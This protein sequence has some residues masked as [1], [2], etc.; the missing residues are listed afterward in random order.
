MSETPSLKGFVYSDSLESAFVDQ[1]PWIQNTSIR[2]NIIGTAAVVCDESWYRDVILACALDH[3]I[4]ALPES[5]GTQPFY[6]IYQSSSIVL[7]TIVG[8][9]GIS[10]SN[11]QKQRV[12]LARALYSKK[13]LMIIDD[14]FS[15]LDK[16]T[17]ERV[18][19]NFFG[20][21]GLLRLS[22]ITAILVTHAVSRLSYA[23]HIIALNSAGQ[24]SEQGTLA[25]LQNSGG[26]V[27]GLA[28]KHRYESIPLSDQSVEELSI[29]AP[30][31]SRQEGVKLRAKFETEEEDLNRRIGEFST[32]KYFFSSIGWSTCIISFSLLILAGVS[33]KLNELLLSYWTNALSAH[34]S[35]VNN[36]YLGLF[37]MLTSIATIAWMI[38][39]YHFFI[40]LVPKSAVNLHA[41]LLHTVMNAPLYFFTSTDTGSLTN[42]SVSLIYRF[43][44]DAN[45][46]TWEQ[47]QSRYVTHRCRSSICVD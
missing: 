17:E 24:I 22:G 25:Q 35:H 5:D 30:S 46:T 26:F 3:D 11:G 13:K 19:V 8:S 38:A 37:G 33:L 9:G 47:I 44:Q 18:F 28:T 1:T 31:T 16:K 41:R 4:A 36:L 15:G 20:R 21:N 40:Y 27:E 29:P 42:R 34:G 32:Y 43:G 10:L 6:E 7:E 12:A 2:Q 45:V 23:D 14:S 39:C